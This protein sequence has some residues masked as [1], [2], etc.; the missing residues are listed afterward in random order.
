M[1]L[2]HL[3]RSRIVS[4]YDRNSGEFGAVVSSSKPND[5]QNIHSANVECII[6]SK[7]SDFFSVNSVMS[8]RRALVDRISKSFLDGPLR[9][10]VC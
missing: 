8:K 6:S 10:I 1:R 3:Q 7:L 5:I 4:R 9:Y 2:C